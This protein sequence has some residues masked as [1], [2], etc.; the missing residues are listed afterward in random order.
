MAVQFNFR[1]V[2][3]TSIWKTFVFDNLLFVS[4]LSKHLNIKTYL[5]EMFE[6]S[7]EHVRYSVCVTLFYSES[8]KAPKVFEPDVCKRPAAEEQPTKIWRKKT[9]LGGE[10]KCF[11]NKFILIRLLDIMVYSLV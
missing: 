7:H 5:K 8:I 6:G 1:K 4:V 10:L 9:I 3:W 2:K 11:A